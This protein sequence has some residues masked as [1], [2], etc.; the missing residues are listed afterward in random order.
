MCGVVHWST[1]ENRVSIEASGR[2]D[3]LS[4]FHSGHCLLSC[5]KAPMMRSTALG[6]HLP[7]HPRA[8]LATCSHLKTV[9][10]E[11][12]L[13]IVQEL[14]SR[15][16]RTIPKGSAD[17]RLFDYSVVLENF[18]IHIVTSPSNAAFVS[19]VMESSLKRSISCT[20]LLLCTVLLSSPIRLLSMIGRS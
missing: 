19:V 16:R 20:D 3:G 17:G 4:M 11:L 14:L 13:V 1:A 10:C 8:S 15:T 9:P 18:T 2:T 7:T 6:S 12:R 5:Y